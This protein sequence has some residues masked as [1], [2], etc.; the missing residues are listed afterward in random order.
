MRIVVA[1]GGNALLRRGEPMTSEVQRKNFAD[2]GKPGQKHIH[3]ARRA[4]RHPSDRA[5]R[6]GLAVQ[7]QL[8]RSQ[9]ARVSGSDGSREA[10]GQTSGSGGAPL[11]RPRIGRVPAAAIRLRSRLRRLCVSPATEGIR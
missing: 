5:R 4:G 3:R 6:E 8:R 2:W 9:L 1:L 10:A 11:A 7:R